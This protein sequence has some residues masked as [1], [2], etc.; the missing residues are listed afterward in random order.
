MDQEIPG[1]VRTAV[2]FER[3]QPYY[4]II[5]MDPGSHPV[6]NDKQALIAAP[7]PRRGARGDRKEPCEPRPRPSAAVRRVARAAERGCFDAAD[8]DSRGVAGRRCDVDRA[9]WCGPPNS[10]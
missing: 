4:P 10:L 5:R 1:A 8:R 9:A 2:D 3:E 6:A 7:P